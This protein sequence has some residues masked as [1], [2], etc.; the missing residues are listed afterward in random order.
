[1]LDPWQEQGCFD[2]IADSLG[3]R[4]V[5]D[6]PASMFPTTIARDDSNYLARIVIKN[7]GMGRIINNKSLKIIFIRNEV[8]DEFPITGP[9]SD[10]RKVIKSKY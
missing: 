9:S 6:Y 2:T 1:M 3:Y 8:R 10:L 4:L 7:I 5:I